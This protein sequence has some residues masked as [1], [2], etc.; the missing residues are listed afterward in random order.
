MGRPGAGYETGAAVGFVAEKRGP[1]PALLED[2]DSAAPAT[3]IFR[4]EPPVT[5]A[6]SE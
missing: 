1:S 4:D 2:A 3:V 5:D 6:Q